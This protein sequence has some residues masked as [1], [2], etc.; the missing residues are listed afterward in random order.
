MATIQL[1]LVD[2]EEK[3]LNAY[4]TLLEEQEINALVAHNG[5]DALRILD[6]HPV[7]VVVLDIRMP[8]L[9]PTSAGGSN[10]PTYFV[11]VLGTWKRFS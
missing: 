9:S 5:L 1:L 2:D 6:E 7:D 10:P 8:G 3:V 4:R 11:L